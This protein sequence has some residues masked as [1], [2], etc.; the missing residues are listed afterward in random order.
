MVLTKVRTVLWYLTRLAD[1]QGPSRVREG[2]EG[3]LVLYNVV[4]CV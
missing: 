4:M 2:K 3:V 1:W